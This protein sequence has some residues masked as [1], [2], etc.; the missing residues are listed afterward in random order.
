MFSMSNSLPHPES[1]IKFYLPQPET[2]VV[3][4]SS[5]QPIDTRPILWT[6]LS[7]LMSAHWGKPNLSRL[8]KEAGVGLASCDRI[9]KQSTSL[10]LEL[11]ESV[12]GVFGLQAWQILTPDLDPLDPPV[13]YLTRSEAS[14]YRTFKESAKEFAE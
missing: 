7:A 11:V 4:R 6:N 14:K 2:K 9:K 3:Y 5:M 8:S 12:A 1:R 13:L 10:G